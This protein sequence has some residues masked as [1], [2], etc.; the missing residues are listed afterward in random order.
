MQSL[1]VIANSIVG[2]HLQNQG[3]ATAASGGVAVDPNANATRI[4]ALQVLFHDYLCST[5][6]DQ[7]FCLHA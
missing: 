7:S 1:V 2:A 4:L 6:L 5:H 3:G